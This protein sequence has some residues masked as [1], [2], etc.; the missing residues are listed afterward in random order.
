M[1]SAAAPFGDAPFSDEG[2]RISC[3]MVTADRR[4]LAERAVDCFLAQTYPNRELVV[5]DDGAQDYAP[6]LARVPPERL[7]HRRL[8][9]DPATT[10]G[11]LRNLSLDLARG[12]L[13]TQ[14]D[15]DDW[16]DPA[17]LARQVVALG[18]AAACWCPVALM[19]LAE[20][21]WTDRPYIGWFKGG[22]PSTIL[23]RRRDDIRY[24][25]ERR[26]ED[27][28]YRDQWRRLGH[29]LL[30]EGEAALLIRCFH[31]G[32]TWERTHFEKRIVLA[33]RDL[34]EWQVRRL[35]GR[36]DGYSRFRLTTR[37]RAS[38]DAFA[39]HSRALGLFA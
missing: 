1:V 6:L 25:P 38:F 18:G 21:A 33:P 23:H 20:P 13:I 24:P 17:R 27:S 4:Q 28:I 36:T 26:G 12:D 3:L 32:N 22:V 35:L 7:I 2:A 8:P 15:D 39:A 11:A 37:Q 34:V 16:F 30:D 10:L 19:H 9:K 31:G 14:W 29:R 5:V